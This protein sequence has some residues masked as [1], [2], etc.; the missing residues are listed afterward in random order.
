MAIWISSSS[1]VIS[2]PP[3]CSSAIRALSGPLAN[4]VLGLLSQAVAA[5]EMSVKGERSCVEKLCVGGGWGVV[6]WPRPMR[7]WRV[8]L[9]LLLVLLV[10]VLVL[11]LVQ[12][13]ILQ[14]P[15]G[16]DVTEVHD[17]CGPLI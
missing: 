3:C 14:G 17:A 5:A 2:A 15:A 16:H 1:S 7:R 11:V 9:L 4:L 6:R 8:L 13:P 10:L 12:S